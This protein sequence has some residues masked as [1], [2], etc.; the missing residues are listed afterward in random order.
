MKLLRNLLIALFLMQGA[1]LAA[2]VK[3]AW[4][5]MPADQAWEKVRIYEKVGAT[6]TQKGEVAGNLTQIT[7]TGITPGTHIL[8]ARAFQTQLESADSNTVTAVINP[9]NP[10]NLRIVAEII[11]GEDGNVRIRL[12]DPAA[13]S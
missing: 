5:P 10:Q 1:A 3:L 9:L 2:D 13:F 7:L 12:L 8:I 4:D 6:Y 11:V